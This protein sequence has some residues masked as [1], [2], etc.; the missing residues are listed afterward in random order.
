M[1]LAPCNLLI[2]HLHIRLSQLKWGSLC[3]Y[4]SLNDCAKILDFFH[5]LIGD[6]SLQFIGD[7]H[8]VQKDR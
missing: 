5:E 2:S 4:K 8:I 6:Y 7:L 3:N 1:F